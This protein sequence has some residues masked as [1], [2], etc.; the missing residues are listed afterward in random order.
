[1]KAARTQAH[2]HVAFYDAVGTDH[3]RAIN[4]AHGEA[5]QVIIVGIHNAGMLGHLAADKRAACLTATF[6][7]AAHNLGDMLLLQLANGDIVQEEQGHGPGADDVVDALVQQVGIVTVHLEDDDRDGQA[8]I[9]LG[10]A[11][12]LDGLHVLG[13]EF[14]QGGQMGVVAFLTDAV[15][16]AHQL[17]A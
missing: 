2:E 4:N 8:L 7:D 11:F 15:A 1:M 14:F 5:R 13:V 17:E 16:Q 3:L 10:L 9:L 6:R 12:V